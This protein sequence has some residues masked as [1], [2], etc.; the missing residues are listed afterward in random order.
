VS[1]SHAPGQPDIY[2]FT[3]PGGVQLQS[4]IDPGS[5]GPSQFHVTAFQGTTGLPLASATLSVT[6]AGGNTRILVSTRLEA[7]HFVANTT[8][9]AGS[10]RFAIAA[11]TQ[12]GR[13]LQANFSQTIGAT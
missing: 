3:F 6:P 12:D 9:S 7:D 13:T 8:L 10:W 11:T 1:V 5:A 2:T 4:Y